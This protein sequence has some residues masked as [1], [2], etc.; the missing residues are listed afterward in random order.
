MNKRADRI[1][2]EIS[3]ESVLQGYGYDV[4]EGGGEQQFRCDLHGDGQ[5]NAPSARVYPQTSSWFCFA[6]GKSRD[7]I[8]TVLEKE[9][10]SF[11]ES[12]TLLE[13]KY[14]LSGWVQTRKKDLY[15]EE[16]TDKNPNTIEIE[17]LAKRT[18][19]ILKDKTTKREIELSTAIKLWEAF[20]LIKSLDLQSSKHWYTLL[21]KIP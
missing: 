1:K 10:L 15:V 21:K 16:N 8:S 13:K 19:Q 9:G 4:Y 17:N 6:C 5:D 3:I 7:A 18:H 2:E 12:C 20:D 11:S 14:G